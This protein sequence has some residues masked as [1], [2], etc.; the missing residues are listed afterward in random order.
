MTIHL[1]LLCY[2]F[3]ALVASML[4]PEEFGHYMAVGLN[5][6]TNNR[7]MFFDVDPNHIDKEAIEY[8]KGLERC[9]PHT[10]GSPKRST[11]LCIY[12]ALEHVSREGLKK[13][14]LTT[15]DGQV[16]GLDPS[17]YH[18]RE[19]DSKLPA[20]KMYVELCPLPPRVV[21]TL[22]PEEYGRFMTDLERPVHVPR[23]LFCD[24]KIDRE[25]DGR[26]AGYLPYGDHEHIE[27]CLDQL[28]PPEKHMKIVDRQPSLHAF[29]RTIQQGFY[30]ADPTGITTFYFPSAREL[31]EQHHTWWRSAQND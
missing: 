9:V 15:R 14:Y 6:R 18:Q 22:S 11:Y 27:D 7:V 13:L 10:D 28:Q 29:Y 3:D 2:K 8:D 4:P 20:E 23:L 25:S 17:E 19:T 24:S 30:V 1:Y 12:R 21:S 5:R 16:L 31:D 26:I